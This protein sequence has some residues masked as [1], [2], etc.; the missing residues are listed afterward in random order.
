MVSLKEIKNT[1]DNTEKREEFIREN[2]GLIYLVINRFRHRG[3][4]QE[5][6][7]QLAA[8][9]L[10]KAMNNFEP[11]YGTQFST[12]AVPIMMGEIKRFLRDNRPIR[13]SR[14]YAQLAAKAAAERER[15]IAQNGREPT[16]T[17]IAKAL[18]VLPE[19]LSAALAAVQMPASLDEAYGE[20]EA[21]LKEELCEKEDI[22]LSDRLALRELIAV[23][24]EREQKI[25]RWR[26]INEDSQ[27]KIAERLGIS[28]VQVSRLEKKIL[29]KLH[30]EMQQ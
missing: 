17:E 6:L 25:I 11:D 16:V 29:L 24:P 20:T 26:Y 12:Y 18:A 14:S 1:A 5:E 8:L 15:L 22:P 4:E 19:D 10:I 21:T 2:M 28:Q 23:L 30:F 3:A 7:F 27:A 9:G 13:I